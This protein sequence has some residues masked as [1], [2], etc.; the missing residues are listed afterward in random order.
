[1]TPERLEEIRQAC[2]QASEGPWHH[3]EHYNEIVP[4]M[5]FNGNIMEKAD[6]TFIAGARTW[7]PE[8]LAYIEELESRLAFFESAERGRTALEQIALKRATKR[9]Y[10]WTR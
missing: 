5:D 1:M 10:G 9:G 3:S 4:V 6:A 2:S 8:L 7:V